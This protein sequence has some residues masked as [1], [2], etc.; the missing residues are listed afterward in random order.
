MVNTAD[1][2]SGGWSLNPCTPVFIFS[3]KFSNL[4]ESGTFWREVAD[5]LIFVMEFFSRNDL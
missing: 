1:C 2:E 3:C 5:I 4:V